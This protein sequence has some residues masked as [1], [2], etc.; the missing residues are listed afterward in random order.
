MLLF[1]HNVQSQSSSVTRFLVHCNI[2]NTNETSHGVPS[3]VH[4]FSDTGNWNFKICETIHS[5]R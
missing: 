5:Q 3:H 4:P 1:E 2:I